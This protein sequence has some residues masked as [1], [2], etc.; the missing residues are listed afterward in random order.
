[1]KILAM[2]RDRS[3]AVAM[4][5]AMGLSDAEPEIRRCRP[6]PADDGFEFDQDSFAKSSRAH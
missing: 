4:L 1:M 5:K 6:P 2:I 3:V